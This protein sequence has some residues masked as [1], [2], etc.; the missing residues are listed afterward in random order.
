[1]KWI[2][3]SRR[4][5]ARPIVWSVACAQGRLNIHDGKWGYLIRECL[6]FIHDRHQRE[7]WLVRIDGFDAFQTESPL[8][9][10]VYDDY[11]ALEVKPPAETVRGYD[12]VL[13]GDVIE[14]LEKRTGERLLRELLGQNGCIVVTT[15]RFWFEQGAIGGNSYEEQRSYWSPA[16]FDGLPADIEVCGRHP[17]GGSTWHRA[18]IRAPRR[19]GLAG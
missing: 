11:R 16:D 8:L 14:H 2:C 17:H 7:D 9:G 10:W 5:A 18:A 4:V 1:M 3:K 15:P 12:L 19:F 13:L 6:D